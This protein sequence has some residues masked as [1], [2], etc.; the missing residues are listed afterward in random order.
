MILLGAFQ[1]M[2]I[3]KIKIVCNIHRFLQILIFEFFY[4]AE[5]FII[6]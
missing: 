1:I 3:T 6:Y 5:K 4:R 2:E